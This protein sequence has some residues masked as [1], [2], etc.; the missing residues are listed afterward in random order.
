M[1]EDIL[2]HLEKVKRLAGGR[3]QACCPVHGDKNPS[4]SLTEKDGKVLIHC[5]ACGA[6]GIDVVRELGLPASVLFA[7]QLNRTQV[8]GYQ[9]KKI[10]EELEY[11][12]MFINIYDAAVERNETISLDDNRKYR[13]HKAK[14][15]GIKEKLG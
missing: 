14:V 1:I 8:S 13:M 11:S 6:K 10:L 9:K 12:K 5:F 2:G 4:M 3:Y 7:D 15:Q